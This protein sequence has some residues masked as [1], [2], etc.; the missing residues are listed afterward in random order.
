MFG[1]GWGLA[2]AMSSAL[3]SALSAF[4]LARY[5]LRLRRTSAVLLAGAP[6]LDLVL[7]VASVLDL[8][9]GSTAG[10]AHGLLY[11]YFS[12]KEQ[13]LE[14]VFRENWS[15]LLA[16]FARIEDSDEPERVEDNDLVTRKLE[17]LGGSAAARGQILRRLAMNL[18]V[19]GE[20]WIVGVPIL[21]WVVSGL[22]M[23][24]KPIER[25][26]GS[27]SIHSGANSGQAL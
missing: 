14:T 26:V 21:L 2:V 9:S 17:A 19:A 20:G 13:V 24:A 6:V 11:H 3:L 7:L 1:F 16:A 10:V 18:I 15:E 4:L 12:S 5:V 25:R 8:R 27:N 23:V 22:I